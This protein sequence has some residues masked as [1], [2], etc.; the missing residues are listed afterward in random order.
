MTEKVLVHKPQRMRYATWQKRFQPVPNAFSKNP[1]CDGSLFET[2]GRGHA[3]VLEVHKEKPDCVWTM[4]EGDNG[5]W[6][7]VDGYHVVNRV[8]YLVT[9][10]PCT[11]HT[12]VA[13]PY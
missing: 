8:G 6:Y 7:I 12:G 9:D 4:V 5:R 11:S 1:G 13:V 2:G 3:H 10:A